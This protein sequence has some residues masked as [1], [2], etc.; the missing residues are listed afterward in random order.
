MESEI[1]SCLGDLLHGN[2]RSV[3]NYKYMTPCGRKPCVLHGLIKVHTGANTNDKVPPF[4]A[5]FSA[6]GNCNYNLAKFFVPILKQLTINEY[7]VK[8]SFSFAKEI[9]DQG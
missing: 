7:T 1:K 3:V 5:I 6:L 2:Y 8:D 4:S 9:A